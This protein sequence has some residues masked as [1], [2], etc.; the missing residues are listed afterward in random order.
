MQDEIKVSEGYQPTHQFISFVEG[1]SSQAPDLSS[2]PLQVL[3]SDHNLSHL[4]GGDPTGGFA[5]WVTDILVYPSSEY[6]EGKLSNNRVRPYVDLSI[7]NYNT[8][9]IPSAVHDY[10]LYVDNAI[11][12]EDLTIHG[13]TSFEGEVRANGKFIPTEIELNSGDFSVSSDGVI[14]GKL[15]TKALTEDI[16]TD[17]AITNDKSG[18]IFQCKGGSSN[19]TITLPANGEDGVV[20]TFMN[21]DAGK[22]VTFYNLTRARGSILSEQFS[23]ATIYWAGD[24]WYAFGDLV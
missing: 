14:K 2:Y 1:S 7:S 22:T 17:T 19:T 9:R 16:S 6:W 10:D 13:K 8:L 12:Y 15:G 20:F 11:I 5:P 3:G 4:D 21:C 23:A 18:T 24:A